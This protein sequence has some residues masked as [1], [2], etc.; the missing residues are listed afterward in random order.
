MGVSAV[1]VKVKGS[2]L[3]A[4]GPTLITHWGMSGPGI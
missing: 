3:K 4:S 1:L 2:K